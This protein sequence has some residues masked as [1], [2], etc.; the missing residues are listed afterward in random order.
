[1]SDVL[2]LVLVGLLFLATAGLVWLCGAVRPR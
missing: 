2:V 1:M